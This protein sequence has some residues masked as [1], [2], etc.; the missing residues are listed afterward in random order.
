MMM[1]NNEHKTRN[2]VMKKSY[3]Q[4]TDAYSFGM[5]EVKIVTREQKLSENRYVSQYGLLQKVTNG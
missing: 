3:D 2:Y 5:I 1:A 4:S